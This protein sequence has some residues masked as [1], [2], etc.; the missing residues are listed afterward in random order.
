MHAPA[1]TLPHPLHPPRT[2]APEGIVERHTMSIPLRVD[3]H[4][5]AVEQQGI[6]H[7]AG[8]NA[9]PIGCPMLA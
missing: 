7:G 5:V 9:A 6:W 3:Q 8:C 2:H 1:T 4:A